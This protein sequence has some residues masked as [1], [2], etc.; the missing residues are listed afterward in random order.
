MHFAK[1]H[2]M[3]YSTRI[4]YEFDPTHVN[5]CFS[6]VYI[7]SCKQ[8]SKNCGDSFT[9]SYTLSYKSYMYY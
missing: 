8:V 3:N 9:Q 4:I 2:N 5:Y 1:L 7:V 6:Y